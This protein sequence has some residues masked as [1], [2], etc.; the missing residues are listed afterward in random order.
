MSEGTDN[1]ELTRRVLDAW[2]RRDAEAMVALWDPEGAWYPALEGITEGRSYSGHP[3]IR[4][5]YRDLAR[6]MS[7]ESRIE[8]REIRNLG[9]RVLGLGRLW[10]R[11]ASGVELDQELACLL[12]WRDGKCVEGRAWL[13]NAEGLAAAGLGD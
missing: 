9:D 2:N 7:D 6:V 3:G 5:Y 8:F 10:A 12:T 11:F 13:S 1:V 4:Q